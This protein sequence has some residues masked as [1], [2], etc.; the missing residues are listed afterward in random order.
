MVQL[1]TTNTPQIFY[2]IEVFGRI[3]NAVSD[4]NLSFY[5]S[6]LSKVLGSFSHT[7]GNRT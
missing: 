5:L 6:K 1:G 4:L 7:K 2:E 3:S